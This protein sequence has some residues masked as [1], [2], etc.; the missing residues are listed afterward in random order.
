MSDE[1]RFTRS[2]DQSRRSF[3]K[4]LIGVA[5]TAPVIASF[6]LDSL[7]AAQPGIS[8]PNQIDVQVSAS[9]S[10]STGGSVSAQATGD[11]TGH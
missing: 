7:A 8:L 1:E 2:I 11:A 6:T 5:F 9:G 4:K 10:V 3:I